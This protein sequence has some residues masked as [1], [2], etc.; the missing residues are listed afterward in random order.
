M[1][2]KQKSD[3]LKVAELISKQ[4]GITVKSAQRRIQRAAKGEAKNPTKDLTKYAKTKVNKTVKKIKAVRAEQ[5]VKKDAKLITDLEKQADAIRAEKEKSEEYKPETETPV[6][7]EMTAKFT[8]GSKGDIRMRT[9]R[10]EM[11]ASGI[12]GGSLAEALQF[13]QNEVDYVENIE[14]FQNVV[15][16]GEKFTASDF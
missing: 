1:S 16:N 4:T 15:V 8:L 7:V 9:V 12:L 3:N 10:Q 11:L 2:K 14:D 5:S 13:F 6:L